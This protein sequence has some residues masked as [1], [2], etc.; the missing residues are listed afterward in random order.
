M[1]CVI[2]MVIVSIPPNAEFGTNDH[3]EDAPHFTVKSLLG[4]RRIKPIFDL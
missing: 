4:N 2:M 1:G 3:R